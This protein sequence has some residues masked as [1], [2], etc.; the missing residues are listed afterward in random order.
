MSRLLNRWLKNHNANIEWSYDQLHRAGVYITTYTL[1]GRLFLVLEAFDQTD[2][3]V[4]VSLHAPMQAKLAALQ[5]YCQL[6]PR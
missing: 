2:I 3:F 4:P 6:N 5:R 1:N